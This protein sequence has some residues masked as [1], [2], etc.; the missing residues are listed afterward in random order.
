MA[1]EKILEIACFNIQS[2]VIA[3][4]NGADRI[5]L[6]ENYSEGGVTPS[7]EIIKEV[8]KKI[9][10]PLHVIIRPRAGDF[11]YTASE[12]QTM[13]EQILFCREHNINGVVFGILKEDNTVNVEANKSLKQLAGPLSVTFHRAIDQCAKINEEFQK[14]IDIGIDR[15][16]TSGGQSSA[17]AGINVLADLQKQFGTQ[18]RIMPGGG[19]R[20]ANLSQLMESNCFEFH[21]AATTGTDIITDSLEVQ[22]MRAILSGI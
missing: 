19:I 16:L 4:K 1:S 22:T 11:I 12:L 21:S 15:V 17:P 13:K 18:I 8:R 9:K 14:L 3:E 10:I 5:E 6:C 2:A 20:S 7:F